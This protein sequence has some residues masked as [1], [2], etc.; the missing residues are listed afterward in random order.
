MKVNIQANGN[1]A[2]IQLA[3]KLDSSLPENERNRVLE[4]VQPGSTLTLDFSRTTSVTSV[5]LRML[6][7][8]ARHINAVGGSVVVQDVPQELLD[9]AEAAG[10]LSLYR[11]AGPAASARV[12]PRAPARIDAYPTHDHA[13]FGL[14]PGYPM[15][16]GASLTGRGVNFAVYSRHATECTLVLYRPDEVQPYAEIPFLPEFRVGDVFAMTVFDLDP[17]SLEYGFRMDGP[18]DPRAGHRFDATKILLDPMA[19]AVRGRDVWG[20]NGAP[21][22][23]RRRAALVPQDFD[24]QGDQ[25]L[26]IPMADL[27]IY[28]MHVRGF[29]RSPTSAVKLAGT[30]AGIRDKIPYLKELGVNCLELM[31]VF[32]FDELENDRS[33][34]LTGER[35][36]NYWGY[37]TVGFFAP[38]AGFAATGNLGMQVDEFKTL[39]RELHRN[40]I[41]VILDVVF[42]HSAEGNENGPTISFRGLDNRTYYMLTPDGEY[43]NFSGCGNTLNCNHPVVRDFVL[44]CLRFWVAE[45]HIDGFRFDLASILG[46]DPS[47]APL[48]NPP[49]LESLALDP[50][51]GKTKLVAEA[52]DAG[53]LYQVGTFPAYGRWAEWNGKYRDCVRKFLKGD[54]EQVT[55]LAQRLSGSPDL[56]YY[57]GPASSINFITAHDG[58]TLA[59]LVSFNDKHN[60]A[61][62]EENR[63]GANDNHSWNCGVEGPTDD[64]QVL[65]LRRRQIKN[66]L[67]MLLLSQGPPMLLMGD[68]F[69]RTQ[70]GNNNTYCHDGPLNWLD[71]DLMKSNAEL[72]RFCRLLIAFR[73]QH[74]ALRN[75]NY[76]GLLQ[77]GADSFEISWHGV[78]PWQPDWAPY[79]RTLAMMVRR[80]IA[81]QHD[82]V[83]A[84]FNMYWAP[85]EFTLPAPVSGQW[86]LFA[87]TGA[88][89]PNDIYDPGQEPLLANQ[90]ILVAARST[91]ILTAG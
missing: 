50:V 82:L 67:A 75:P 58:F 89:S 39:V 38:K 48:A 24:W 77:N 7:L 80:T 79:S 86:R 32:E 15:P 12:Q 46:R 28:E 73:K 5:G 18:H 49:L 20:S 33:N 76:A 90:S 42:N 4:L 30:Y 71:W 34:P 56:Y 41:E 52:W 81:G 11:Q 43:Y 6:L 83:Y 91:L 87:D 88:A 85:L 36:F 64:P 40:G 37:S 29:T 61:N 68:E 57:R 74:P 69:G 63:D 23:V 45:Y 19:H 2:V 25:P 26:G 59:D 44:N 27:V 31:P 53:G 54:A 78:Q 60:E 70:Q 17:D 51:L 65:A 84:A 8:L 72:Y 21:D 35:L 47:G 10:F 22:K 13:G 16:L 14:R 62:G 3:G 66:A 9:A 55:E 1:S